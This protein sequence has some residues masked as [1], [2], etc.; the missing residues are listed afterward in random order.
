MYVSHILYNLIKKLSF[1]S[2]LQSNHFTWYKL[3]VTTIDTDHKSFII[4]AC[5]VINFYRI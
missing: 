2:K 1:S 5:V 3:Q 4:V